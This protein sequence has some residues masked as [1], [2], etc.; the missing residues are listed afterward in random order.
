MVNTKLDAWQSLIVA[1]PA[2]FLAACQLLFIGQLVGSSAFS[3]A[4]AFLL[5]KLLNRSRSPFGVSTPVRSRQ[6]V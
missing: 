5:H 6:H 3:A 2:I 1:R 4:L